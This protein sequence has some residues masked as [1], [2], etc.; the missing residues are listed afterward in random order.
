[1]A[2]C[3]ND[4]IKVAK[5]DNIAIMES[6]DVSYKERLEK[7][8]NMLMNQDVDLV[9]CSQEWGKR[10]HNKYNKIVSYNY[11]DFKKISYCLYNP[12]LIACGTFKRELWDRV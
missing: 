7:E 11:D 12:P 1:M 6:D 10:M 2:D 8:Y 9:M 4:C 3:L 5:T